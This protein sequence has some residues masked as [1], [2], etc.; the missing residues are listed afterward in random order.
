MWGE[1]RAA[2]SVVAAIPIVITA[3]VAPA[4]ASGSKGGLGVPTSTAQSGSVPTTRGGPVRDLSHLVPQPLPPDLQLVQPQADPLD[5]AVVA[6]RRYAQLYLGSNGEVLYLDAETTQPAN[7]AHP[8]PG[9]G[10]QLV[11]LGGRPTILTPYS[12]NADQ[13]LYNRIGTVFDDRVPSSRAGGAVLL[14]TDGT[15]DY[16]GVALNTADGERLVESVAAMVRPAAGGTFTLP[17]P[18][19]SFSLQFSGDPS[20]QWRSSQSPLVYGFAS[21]I[22]GEIDITITPAK[23]GFV[24]SFLGPAT[25]A[26]DGHQGWIL[27]S[28]ASFSMKSYTLFWYAK[29]GE[30][31]ILTSD[32]RA[33]ESAMIALADSL[34]AIDDASWAKLTQRISTS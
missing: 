5:P 32:G 7:W 27:A 33:S 21:N 34:Q 9:P 6:I 25:L 29:P 18:G 12:P 13:L 30:M 17:S 15:L 11:Q 22:L 28:Q 23:S 19:P 8:T 2:T 24:E 1:T 14:W 16:Y 31:A 3:L 26:V 10:Q 4:C 20:E